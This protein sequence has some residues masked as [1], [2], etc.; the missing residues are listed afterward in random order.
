MRNSTRLVLRIL[1]INEN[2]VEIIVLS[3]SYMGYEK[4][5]GKINVYFT[6]PY[7]YTYYVTVFSFYLNY[8]H[9]YFETSYTKTICYLHHNMNTHIGYNNMQLLQLKIVYKNL[10]FKS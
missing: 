1:W 3:Y 2:V 10:N 4:H 8:Y 7:N 5:V 9:T 6:F